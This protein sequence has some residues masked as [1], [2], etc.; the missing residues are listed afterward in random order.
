MS[1]SGLI[2]E[3]LA[4]L[5][6][7]LPGQI[8]E[9]LAD[10]FDQTYRRYLDQGLDAESAAAAAIAEFGEPQVV[11]AAFIR[12]SP[13]RCAARKL[14]L[15]GPVVGACWAA[16]LVTDRAWTW[17]VPIVARILFGVLLITVI[18]LLATAALGR[19]Y[20]SVGRAGTAG[21]IG[22]AALDAAMLT[23]VALAVPAVVWPLIPAVAASVGRLTFAARALRPV[24]TG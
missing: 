11:V 24:L 9:E 22:I 8:V 12:A 2:K 5:S 16:A 15:I 18:S 4:E 1:E 20:R 19:Q 17:P 21:C 10:G 14:L 6:A 13:A 3:Y 23:T 7:R